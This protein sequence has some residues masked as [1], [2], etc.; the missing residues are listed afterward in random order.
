MR[1]GL[2]SRAWPR[3]F[4]LGS[5]CCGLVA[6]LAALAAAGF[7]IVI[8]IAIAVFIIH[9]DDTQRF[10]GHIVEQLGRAWDLRC[11]R[12]YARSRFRGSFHFSYTL[13][14]VRFVCSRASM[15]LYIWGC[16]GLSYFVCFVAMRTRQNHMTAARSERE[17]CEFRGERRRHRP[18][19]SSCPHRL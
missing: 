17:G 11:Y 9:L 5:G 13:V 18:P 7:V 4:R 19:V 3:C 1:L 15:G 16:D 6:S 2:R 12:G 14:L 10:G 8:L